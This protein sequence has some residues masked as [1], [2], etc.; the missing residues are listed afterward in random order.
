MFNFTPLA[1]AQSQSSASQ[2]LLE[3]DGGVRILINIGWDGAFDAA[4][5]KAIDDIASSLSFILLTH[6]TITHLGAY[7]Y[8]CKHIPR[9]ALMPVY[10]TRPVAALGRTLLQD[11]YTSNPLAASII[12]AA[13]LLEATYSTNFAAGAESLNIL[14]QKPDAEEI[15]IYCNRIHVIE[16]SQPHQPACA[17]DS[18]SVDGL[19]ITAFNAG[20]TPGGS[21][22]HIQYGLEAIV[23]AV[24]WNLA[25]DNILEGANWL[26]HDSSQVIEQLQRP[27]TLICSSKGAQS[28]HLPLT[29]ERRDAALLAHVTRTVAN[30][31]IVLI[32]TDSSARLL[33]IAYL[34]EQ[35]W[36][37]ESKGANAQVYRKSRIAISST[38]A[39]ATVK[40]AQSMVNWLRK[41]IA[42]DN[43]VDNVQDANDAKSKNLFSSR[44]IKI[45]ERKK[46]LEKLIRKAAPGIILASDKSLQWGLSNDAFRSLCSD[47]KNLLIMTEQ[48]PP[49]TTT[50]DTCGLHALWSK[51]GQWSASQNQATLSAKTMSLDGASIPFEN[52]TAEKL[53]GEQLA[54]YLQYMTH[55][56]R[57]RGTT[58]AD[59]AL[60]KDLTVEAAD[61][62]SSSSSESDNDDD[63][64]QAIVHQ[65]RALNSTASMAQIKRKTELGNPDLGV[66]V[67]I[68][69]RNVYDYD[70]RGKQRRDKVFPYVVKRVKSDEFGEIIVPADYL[71]AEEK[72]DDVSMRVGDSNVDAPAIGQKRKW[73]DQSSRPLQSRDPRM[74]NKRT[75]VDGTSTQTNN[76]SLIDKAESDNSSSDESDDESS[77]IDTSSPLKAVFT[78]QDISI[79]MQ[80]AYVDFSSLH[81]KRDLHM[82]IPLIRP[83]KL[84]LVGTP[85]D[86]AALAADCKTLLA[87][88]DGETPT[89]ILTP[90]N[91]ECI[92]VSVDTNAWN[93]KL[94][95]ELVKH[96]AWQNVRGLGVVAITGQLSAGISPHT[97]HELE[98]RRKKLKS[99]SQDDQVSNPNTRD[100]SSSK[101]SSHP[102]LDLLS[103]SSMRT[104]SLS[105]R[106]IHVGDTRLADL[107]RYMQASG[108]RAEF[109]GQG[110][111]L[112][113][114]SVI[115]R[116]NAAGT[117]SVEGTP[118]QNSRRARGG[119]D[120]SFFVVRKRIYEGLAVVAGG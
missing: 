69:G 93:L 28:N 19:S 118:V 23:F 94:G 41:D 52:T 81:E 22:W 92:D 51:W 21:I 55:Q 35:H 108:L 34:L 58:D 63:D 83:R 50:A 17:P 77:P 113:D 14:L 64:A 116:K 88:S 40:L 101:A 82:L 36:R 18:P 111:L 4:Q 43:V 66:N 26:D 56:R 65:G 2:S 16:Y 73:A 74:Q 89:V 90:K 84:V 79:H 13:S 30:G 60:A 59:D 96:L 76:A 95:R 114:D 1:G 78:T 3:L 67:L 9:F 86:T 53:Q 117:V 102:I 37:S 48:P 27:T 8:C 10:A 120:M 32:P 62:D 20:H 72:D 71:R 47:P 54:H 85:E 107:R 75:R 11:L 109:R 6:P 46:Q 100:I 12:P 31:G 42:Q 105:T 119:H 5:L 38:T 115:V 80:L 110:T 91:N 57:L 24:D 33:E 98:T 87:T 15:A 7:A 49:L 103:S 112:I 39:G 44:H 70:V 97:T 61:S 106:P 68:K 25:K 99:A 45:I 29:R 104:S